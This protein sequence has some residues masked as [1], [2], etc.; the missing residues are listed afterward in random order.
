[1]HSFHHHRLCAGHADGD[2][3]TV[4]DLDLDD[5][6][7]GHQ[8][9]RSGACREHHLFRFLHDHVNH[10]RVNHTDCDGHCL[11]ELPW[12]RDPERHYE[13]DWCIAKQRSFRRLHWCHDRDRGSNTI[14]ADFAVVFCASSTLATVSSF[15]RG[16][17]HPH[18]DHVNLNT[19]SLHDGHPD[20]HCSNVIVYPLPDY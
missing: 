11:G 6:S 4:A 1:M 9:T 20:T 15:I 12:I 8:L 5:A 7:S 10:H 13:L 19:D 18:Y 2:S 16:L 14:T 3:H 17:Y